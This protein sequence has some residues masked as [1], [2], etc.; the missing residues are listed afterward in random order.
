MHNPSTDVLDFCDTCKKPLTDVDR[1]NFF[2]GASD[3]V[4][5]SR[6]NTPRCMQGT[7]RRE[8]APESRFRHTDQVPDTQYLREMYTILAECTNVGF[9]V[10][11]DLKPG[12]PKYVKMPCIPVPFTKAATPISL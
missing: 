3:G 9:T 12:R 8:T 4:S 6:H 11:R 10:N 7:I 1:A 2:V 5:R